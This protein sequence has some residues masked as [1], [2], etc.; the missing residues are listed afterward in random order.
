MLRTS[1]LKKQNPVVI[2]DQSRLISELTVSA[3]ASRSLTS[4]VNKMEEFQDRRNF[5]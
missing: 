4:A 3:I 2:S 1:H 5:M